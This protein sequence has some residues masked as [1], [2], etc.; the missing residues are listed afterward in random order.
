MQQMSREPEQNLLA[1]LDSTIKAH[2]SYD[3]VLLRLEG[4]CLGRVHCDHTTRQTLQPMHT[5]IS[6]AQS[7][8]GD[9]VYPP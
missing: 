8:E 9:Q 6:I 2:I 1:Y 5:T 3:D 4:G 7:T